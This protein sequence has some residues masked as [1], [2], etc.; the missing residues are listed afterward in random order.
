MRPRKIEGK[1]AQKFTSNPFLRHTAEISKTG[2]KPVYFKPEEGTGFLTNDGEIHGAAMVFAKP[3]ESNGFLK[4]YAEGIGAI[5]G[6]KSAGRTVFLAIYEQLY[7]KE[8]KDKTEIILNYA[9]LPPKI[10]EKISERTF[11]RGINECIKVGLIAQSVAIGLYYV[12]PAFIF[13]GER[14]NIVTQYIKKTEK[15]VTD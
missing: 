3:I 13:N 5:L 14:L 10:R 1:N 11:S 4:V 7:G 15:S 12:N 9:L 6:L 2:W 8:G